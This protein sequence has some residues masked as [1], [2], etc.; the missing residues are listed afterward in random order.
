MPKIF[1]TYFTIKYHLGSEEDFTCFMRG[2]D[3][4]EVKNLLIDYFKRRF[5]PLNEIKFVRTYRVKRNSKFKDKVI[6]DRLWGLKTSVAFPNSSD[7]LAFDKIERKTKHRWNI[8]K[9]RKTNNGFKAGKENWA[10]KNLK[11]K[12]LPHH[13]RRN[14]RYDGKWKEI[15]EEEVIAE[16]EELIKALAAT[17]GNKS[18]AAKKL[19]INRNTLYKRLR[20]HPDVDWDAAVKEQIEDNLK[21]FRDDNSDSRQPPGL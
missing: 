19:N 7:H 3:Y 11:G 5:N 2:E 14:V 20:R 13:E 10:Y 4:K 1:Y 8:D 6:D 9:P 16:R 18:H 17:K 15:P 21:N 12:S